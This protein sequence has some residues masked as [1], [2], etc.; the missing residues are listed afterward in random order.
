MEDESLRTAEQPK[1]L[2]R[3]LRLTPDRIVVALLVAEGFLL[4]SE[5]FHRFAFNQHKGW[6]VLIAVVT[7]GLT[8]LS[9]LLWLTAALL[10]RWRFQYSL[11]SLLV[12]VVVVAVPCSW[13][14]TQMQA[15]SRQQEAVEA[16]RNL[17]WW[18]DQEIVT[19][20][21]LPG[22]E[23]LQTLLGDAFFAEVI[24][25]RVGDAAGWS[26]GLPELWLYRSPFTEARLRRWRG[27]TQIHPLD[28]SKIR[29]TVTDAGLANL[30]AMTQLEELYLVGMAITDTNVEYLKELT[31][32]QVLVLTSPN[33]TDS[34]LKHLKG[35]T[36]LEKLAVANAAITDAGLEHLDRL[37][38][39]QDLNLDNTRVTDAGLDRLKAL[40]EL[41][42]LGLAYT[43]ITDA[44]L[45]RLREWTKLEGLDLAG[46]K[47]TD[48]GLECLEK[49]TQLRYLSLANTHVTDLGLEHLKCLTKLH[50]LDLTGTRVTDA[51][52]GY[53][54]RL[55]ELFELRVK[56]TRV[57]DRRAKEF[58]QALPKRHQTGTTLIEVRD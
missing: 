40:T 5:R 54:K 34:G 7:V 16:T 41:R 13:L 55:T 24:E 1:P 6:T 56:N 57:T 11:R 19:T 22:T 23:W 31:R 4:L 8:L 53:L 28:L 43:P 20:K 49:M 26:Q 10:F 17:G 14:A 44:G 39:L 50:V 15:A 36:Q 3:W 25:V 42:G 47:I 52:L 37:I 27:P 38:H 51:G 21:V 58:R 12:L 48:A 46:T 2:L 33:V 9:M 32:L 29:A 45:R 35:L 18:V 30:K